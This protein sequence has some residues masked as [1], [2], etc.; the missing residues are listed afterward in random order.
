MVVCNDMATDFK[1]LLSDASGDI[2]G[3][4]NKFGENSVKGLGVK[5]WKRVDNITGSLSALPNMEG[6]ATAFFQALELRDIFTNRAGLES[7]LLGKV[8]PEIFQ[9]YAK[10]GGLQQIIAGVQEWKAGAQQYAA[11][12]DM[13]ENLVKAAVGASEALGGNAGLPMKPQSGA[14]QI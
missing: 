4:I 7:A 5:D 2:L 14:I 3:A 9:K 10:H 12:V 8:S 11:L 13:Q 1:K 6:V